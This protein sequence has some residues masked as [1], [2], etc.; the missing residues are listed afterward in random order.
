[1]AS[2]KIIN[3]KK[4]EAQEHHID[5]EAESNESGASFRYSNRLEVHLEG[6]VSPSLH[7]K[8]LHSLYHAE[9]QPIGL[10]S[11]PSH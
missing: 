3:Q 11:A 9:I 2:E 1:M 4:E 6:K 7:V 5:L 10:E 8:L